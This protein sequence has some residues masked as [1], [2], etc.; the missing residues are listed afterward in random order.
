MASKAQFNS[1]IFN[2]NCKSDLMGK[3][4][5]VK[6]LDYYRLKVENFEKERIEWL[7]KLEGLKLKNEEH[8][9][10]E[11]ELRNITSKITDLQ[12]SLSESNIALNQERKKVI[13]YSNEIDTYKLGTKE[14][15]RRMIQLLKFA[16]P[17]S[18]YTQMFFDKRPEIAEKNVSS[19]YNYDSNNQFLKNSVS[20]KKC[21]STTKPTKNSKSKN[22]NNNKTL[23]A[24]SSRKTPSDARQNLIKTIMF[25]TET[26]ESFATDENKCLKKQK[27]E[28]VALY[29]NIIMKMEEDGRLRE[30]EFRLQNL[31]MQTKLAEL[32][33]RNK[34]LEKLNYD[35]T[36]DYMDLKYDIEINNK[37]LNDEYELAKLQNDALTHSLN[38]IIKKTTIEK[39]V[40]RN[41]Y[42]RKT[43]EVTNSLRNQVKA[44]EENANLIKEQYKQIQKIYADK[45]GDLENNL[46]SIT[47]KC[48]DLEA[49]KGIQLDNFEDDIKRYRIELRKYEDYTH[50]LRQLGQGVVDHYE[51]INNITKETNEQFLE[52][53]AKTDVE[54]QQLSKM[55]KRELKEYERIAKG[56][57]ERDYDNMN[58]RVNTNRSFD[59]GDAAKEEMEYQQQQQ[60]FDEGEQQN[61]NNDDD[62]GRGNDDADE[63]EEMM[64]QQTG[65]LNQNDNEYGDEYEEEQQGG[66]DEEEEQDGEYN[67]MN[68]DDNNYG[69][70][71][72]EEE[73]YN[74]N[75]MQGHEEEEE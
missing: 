14:D 25:P 29:E 32:Q 67:N 37:K 20:L 57:Q 28:L 69:D 35:I 74:N 38:D 4:D 65:N 7:T 15:R 22:N 8:Q 73:Q 31:N 6:L 27:E 30:E 52:Q 43:R 19:N 63:E 54:L 46:T 75:N 58:N 24:F 47:N 21:L 16:E 55:I 42:A 11:W 49:I 5:L 40:N 59:E 61:E 10:K 68:Q 39:E 51:Q 56:I 12:F 2:P 70:E 71:E 3:N 50:R 36:K 1:D 62:N 48:K 66:Y 33:K 45:V 26:K 60:Q 53:S 17:I 18:Q 13:H 72:E 44:K 41:E 34:K 64:M 23:S 9:K